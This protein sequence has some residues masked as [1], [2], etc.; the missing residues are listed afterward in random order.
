MNYNI[1][2]TPF[3]WYDKEALEAAKFYTSIFPNSKIITD[4]KF[5]QDAP[6]TDEPVRIVEIELAGQKMQLMNAGP[7]FKFNE[8]IS[9][10]IDCDG[11]EQVDYFWNALLADGGQESQ[12]GWLKDKFGLSWQVTPKQLTEKIRADK[13]GKVMQNMMTMKKIVIA[14]LDK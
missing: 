10:L 9:L 5:D 3:L 12:C 7:F 1:K 2:I 8:S 13:T 4:V 14:D 11:Q 6:G